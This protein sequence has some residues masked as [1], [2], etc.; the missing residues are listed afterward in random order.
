MKFIIAVLA[1]A[2]FTVANGYEYSET[3]G[4]NYRNKYTINSINTTNSSNLSNT[5]NQSNL[6]NVSNSSNI[7]VNTTNSSNLSNTSN[8]SNLTNLFLKVGNMY[9]YS[10]TAGYVYRNKY[11]I[12]YIN[13]T[14]SSN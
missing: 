12:N 14:N 3:A 10:E 1:I 2:L 13:T 4:N 11:T 8:Q 5:T 9:K 6:T 7:T